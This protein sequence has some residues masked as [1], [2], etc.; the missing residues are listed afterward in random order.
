MKKNKAVVSENRTRMEPKRMKL[1]HRFS[2]ADCVVLNW[3]WCST[4][5]GC[6]QNRAPE[7]EYLHNVGQRSQFPVSPLTVL[8]AFFVV[9]GIAPQCTTDKPIGC[10]ATEYVGSFHRDRD[11][12]TL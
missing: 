9:T 12:F 7:L 3:S 4:L 10:C 6:E 11:K 1:F 5:S 8:A 2:P